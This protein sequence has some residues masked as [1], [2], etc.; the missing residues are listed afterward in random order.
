MRRSERSREKQGQ[1]EKEEIPHCQEA[2]EMRNLT[3]LHCF[4]RPQQIL[5]H[6]TLKYSIHLRAVFKFP[7]T[8]PHKTI[9][10]NTLSH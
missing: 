5:N 4:P 3:K 7:K 9:R 10:V 1:K 2:S 8:C 6:I